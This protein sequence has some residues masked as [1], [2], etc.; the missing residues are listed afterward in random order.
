MNDIQNIL[1]I[2][3]PF[4]EKLLK[5]YGEFYPLASVVNLNHEVEQ[6]LLSED[7]ENDFPKSTGV[8]GEI[9]KELRW[10]RDDY[11]AF[12]IFYDVRLKEKQTDA[13]AVLVEHKFEKQAFVFYYPY[14]LIDNE[15]FF[16][17]SWKEMKE[18]EIFDK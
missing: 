5:D 3:F 18:I 1:D 9:K 2:T 4:V 10:R 13:I 12:A 15:L 7:E 11:I 6:L 17:D 8:I 14:K 16:S